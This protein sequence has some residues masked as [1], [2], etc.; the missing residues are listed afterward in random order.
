MNSGSADLIY[1]DPPFNSKANY[2]T[3]HRLK[4]GPA[5]F[6]D[7]WGLDDVNLAWHGEIKHEYPGL[8]SLPTATCEFTAIP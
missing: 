7:T 4:G 1:L 3:P 2:A 5:A 6:K 8:Y